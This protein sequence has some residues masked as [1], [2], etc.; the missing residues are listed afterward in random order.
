MLLRNG[1]QLSPVEG[2][3]ETCEVSELV[4]VESATLNSWRVRHHLF[5]GSGHTTTARYLLSIED[6]CIA[7]LMSSLT[8]HGLPASDAARIAFR[9]IE[10]IN[11][12]LDDKGAPNVLI[13]Y[14]D[15]QDRIVAKVIP[16]AAAITFRASVITR[17]D[18]RRIVS[19]V[20]DPYGI[21]I[22]DERCSVA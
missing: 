4:D 13:F 20:I 15:G 10:T 6:A 3:F 8:R 21:E 16:A 19:D 14:R 7:N 1:E 18:L 11:A 17:V 22:S 9:Q 5:G 2:L 12:L